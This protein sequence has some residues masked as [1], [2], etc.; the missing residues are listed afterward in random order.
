MTKEQIKERWN[1][2][3][4]GFNQWDNLGLDEKFMLLIGA[5]D[6]TDEELDI[7]NNEIYE[8]KSLRRF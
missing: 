5:D 1:R 6:I 2:L 4:D 7:M 3:A 8:E